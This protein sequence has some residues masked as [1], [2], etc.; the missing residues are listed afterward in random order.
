M[1]IP[2]R[3]LWALAI[4]TARA[5]SFPFSIREFQGQ[6]D[7][8]IWSK[9]PHKTSLHGGP[10]G[11]PDPQYFMACN[12]ALDA[13]QVLDL[14]NVVSK[15]CIPFFA[16]QSLST[17]VDISSAIRPPPTASMD[18]DCAICMDPLAHGHGYLES[19]ARRR[20]TGLL[21]VWHHVH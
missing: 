13:L 16:P 8:V 7:V 19:A 10:F 20:A 5:Y 1:H 2:P 14:S 12:A 17:N 21:A 11:L 3:L 18:G 9:I 4:L 15:E 6:R